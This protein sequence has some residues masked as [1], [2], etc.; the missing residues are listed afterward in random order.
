MLVALPRSWRCQHELK[1]VLE[2]KE[3]SIFPGSTPER[4]EQGE[5]DWWCEHWVGGGKQW[6]ETRADVHSTLDGLLLA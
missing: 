2:L 4:R 5:G 6:S 3:A 1:L